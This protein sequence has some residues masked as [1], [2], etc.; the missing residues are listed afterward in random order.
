[1]GFRDPAIPPQATDAPRQPSKKRHRILW[2]FLYVGIFIAVFT[3]SAAIKLVSNPLGDDFS[4][5]WN[6]SVGTVYSDIPYGDGDANKFDLYVPADRSR[7]HYGLVVYLHAGGFTSGD[8]AD[9]AQALQWLCAQGFVAAGI[10]YTL[11]SE[12]HPGANI[13][14]QSLEIK[15]SMDAVVA[16]A[17]KLGYPVNEMAIGGG[18]AG[19]CL[20][21]LYAYRDAAESPVPVR[22][23]FE[24]VGPS[25]FYPEDWGNYGLDKPEAQAEAAGLFGVMTGAKLTPDMFGTPAY[26]AAV[27]DASALLWVTKDAVPTVMAYGTHDTM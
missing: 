16:E 13:L 15:E 27:K 24:A 6:D 4:V 20:A 14:T 18:S 9:D 21:L 2:G 25:S 7:Q 1:M 8:K 11:F 12:Q 23:V 3:L 26:D 17:A 5:D 22:F 19:V 10:N